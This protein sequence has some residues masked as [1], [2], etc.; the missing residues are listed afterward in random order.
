MAVPLLLAERA[1]RDGRRTD[2]ALDWYGALYDEASDHPY[3]F[4]PLN[5]AYTLPT[6]PLVDPLDAHGRL[7]VSKRS[8][9]AHVL[10]AK[11]RVLL[12]AADAVFVEDTPEAVDRARGLYDQ[13]RR[14]LADPGLG[15]DGA[16]TQQAV[17]VAGAVL[18]TPS[19]V[20][21][22]WW[23]AAAQVVDSLKSIPSISGR[24]QAA[25]AVAAAFQGSDDWTDRIDAAAQAVADAKAAVQVLPSIGA[26]LDERQ[27]DLERSRQVVN[28]LPSA[29]SRLDAVS[30]AIA[31]LVTDALDPAPVKTTGFSTTF[32]PARL[33]LARAFSPALV[34]ATPPN[35]FLRGLR[36]R[37]Q[38]NLDKIHQGRNIAGLERPLY[39]RETGVIVSGG[40]GVAVRRQPTPYRAATLLE[41][42]R[43]IAQLAQQ[44]EASFLNALRGPAPR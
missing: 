11:G 26:L 32:S 9:L 39:V 24:T 14:T 44:A 16:A 5:P 15:N 18:Q 4:A 10:M 20:P 6:R 13:A 28:A 38:V 7:T 23:Q 30:R 42:A 29:A 22:V 37:A 35:P 1:R 31:P 33:A 41:R 8:L 12:D 21:D 40:A 43:Q 25:Q 19:G 27:N 3:T 2:E 17:A 34:F 36:L